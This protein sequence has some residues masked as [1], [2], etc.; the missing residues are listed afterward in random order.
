[1][2]DGGSY[3]NSGIETLHFLHLEQLRDKGVRQPRR[4][5]S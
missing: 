5:K 4:R 1:V 3:E 2:G